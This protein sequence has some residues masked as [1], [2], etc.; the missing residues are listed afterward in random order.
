MPAEV[1]VGVDPN[2]RPVAIKQGFDAATR[3]RIAQEATALAFAQQPGVVELA[4]FDEAE[5]RL[6]TAW[7]PGGSLEGTTLDLPGA[8]R[9]LA[10]VA[11]TLADLHDRGIVHGRV[12]AGH[13][14]VGSN[15]EA[16]LTGFAESSLD[17]SV[18]RLVDLRAMAT[19]IDQIA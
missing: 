6:C 18:D 4:G 16:W 17:G 19:L 14:L 15:S 10:T 7:A 9:A 8:T 11:T 1:S 2:G 12:Q 13:V 5:G 3:E